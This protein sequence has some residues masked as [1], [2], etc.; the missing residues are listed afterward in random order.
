VS[1]LFPDAPEGRRAA[2]LGEAGY[3]RRPLDAYFTPAW[4]TAALLDHVRFPLYVREPMCGDG[5]IVAV[6]R[7]R[8]HLVGASDIR[9]YGCPGA[10]IQD[11]LTIGRD[12]KL[13]AI[14]SNPPYEGGA[15]FIG[16]CLWLVEPLRGKV[17]MLLRHEYDCAKERRALF[18]DHPAFAHKL[19]LTKRPKWSADDKASPRFP[20]AWFVWDWAHTGAPTLG[21][22]P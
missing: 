19:T 8:G 13:E 4:C 14:V 22:A 15:R 18:A 17:A 12:A 16:H 2:T 11:V 6:L 5:A 10:V 7:E 20:F 3:E 1:G 21:Y 9:D